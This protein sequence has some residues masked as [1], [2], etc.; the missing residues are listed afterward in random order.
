[1]HQPPL[2]PQQHIDRITLLSEAIETELAQLWA[3][4]EGCDRILASNALAPAVSFD[5]NT[6]RISS[7]A[8]A[9]ETGMRQV[10]AA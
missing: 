3:K 10:E 4:C 6:L 7:R 1:M 9:L 5:G 2:T 8:I